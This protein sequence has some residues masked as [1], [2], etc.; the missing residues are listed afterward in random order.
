MSTARAF[1]SATL[2]ANGKVLVA[3]GC[4]SVCVA[5]A[6]LYDPDT[7]LFSPTGS[8]ST[9]RE[10][11]TA[12]LLADGTVLLTGGDDGKVA[13]ASADRYD[14]DTGLSSPT[15]SMSAPRIVHVATLLADGTLL[16]S[17]GSDPAKK[18]GLASAELY[19]PPSSV[20]PPVLFSLSGDGRGQGA[21]QHADTY[22]IAS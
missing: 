16:L 10:D 5:S 17:G 14:P 21:I 3:G 11:H 20:P 1:F 8:M 15:G 4:N 22:E 19:N 7:G 9:A 2:L 18:I 12:T 6:E 13:F